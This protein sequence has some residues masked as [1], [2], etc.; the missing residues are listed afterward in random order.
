VPA[1]G[2]AAT[3]TADFVRVKKSEQRLYLLHDGKAFAAFHVVFGPHPEGPKVRQGDGRTPEG[4]YVLDTRNAHSAYHR[5]LHVSYPNAAD[6]KRAA[7]LG[8]APGG[9]IMI[10]GQPNGWGAYAA[11]TQRTNWTLGCIALTDEDMDIVW[12]SVPPG[13]PIEIEP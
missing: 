12:D 3:A 7:Q 5:S 1:T 6:R 9:D 8:V 10:H 13:T 2:H 11:A 4:R